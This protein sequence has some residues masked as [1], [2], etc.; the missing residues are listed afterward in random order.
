MMTV[1]KHVWLSLEVTPKYLQFTE[2]NRRYWSD[3]K[4]W[5]TATLRSNADTV[6]RHIL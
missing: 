2:H 6:G 4:E 3:L 1:G 5:P